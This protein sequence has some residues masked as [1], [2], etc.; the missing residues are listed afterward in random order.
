MPLT[1]ALIDWIVTGWRLLDT[2]TRVAVVVLE[3]AFLV[4]VAILVILFTH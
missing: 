3:V 2:P 4:K 1:R